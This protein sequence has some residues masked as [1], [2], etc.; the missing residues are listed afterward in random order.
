MMKTTRKIEVTNG[1]EI[2]ILETIRKPDGS[3]WLHDSTDVHL[4]ALEPIQDDSDTSV[5]DAIRDNGWEIV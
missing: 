1:S 5:A 4:D 3:Y 2:R